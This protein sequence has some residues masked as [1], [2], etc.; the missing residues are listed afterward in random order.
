MQMMPPDQVEL[1]RGL[2]PSVVNITSYI[3]EVP[4]SA[5]MNAGAPANAGPSRPKTDQGSGFVIDPSGVILTNHHVVDGAYDIHVK[6][7]DGTVVSGRVLATAPRIDL[8]L[9]KIDTQHP[10]T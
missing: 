3:N 2:L 7:S 8:A 6:L 9:V 10:L 4:V 5:S 1:I